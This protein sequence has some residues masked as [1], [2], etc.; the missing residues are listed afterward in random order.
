MMQDWK[1]KAQKRENEGMKEGKEERFK[2]INR[3]DGWK[4]F[5]RKIRISLIRIS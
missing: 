3:N 1:Q 5:K 2:K 4:R